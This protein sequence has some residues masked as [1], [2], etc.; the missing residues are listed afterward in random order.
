MLTEVIKASQLQERV[1]EHIAN[2]RD[3]DAL[4]NYK[5]ELATYKRRLGHRKEVEMIEK[6][7]FLSFPCDQKR[8]GFVVEVYGKQVPVYR[9][10]R[11][12]PPAWGHTQYFRSCGFTDDARHYGVLAAPRFNRDIRPE[13]VEKYREE[14]QAG[15]WHDLLS[16]PITI[17]DDGQVINGQHRLAAACRVDWNKVE[18]DP[19]FLVVF[20]VGPEEALHVDGSRRTDRDERMIADRYLKE[21]AA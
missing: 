12:K 16:D 14:M 20:G 10:E 4:S 21:E 8:R 5:K 13:R 2:L 9:P 19:L 15:H 18:N 1:I 7:K 11:P 6:G 17:T 3:P